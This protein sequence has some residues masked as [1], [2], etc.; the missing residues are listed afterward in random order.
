VLL[1]VALGLL[2]LILLG[3]CPVPD[4]NPGVEGTPADV[5]DRPPSMAV[6][7]ALGAET[8]PLAE[9]L[10]CADEV[11]QVEWDL[12]ALQLLAG[13][14]VHIALDNAGRGAADLFAFA[15]DAG[16]HLFGL[17]EDYSELDDERSCSEL[18]WS[19]FGC[20]EAAVRSSA[21]G[22]FVIAVAQWGGGCSEGMS[23]YQIH[24]AVNG[25][26]IDPALVLVQDD[27]SLQ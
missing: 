4:G 27:I 3:A 9:T 13:D 7:E 10:S 26:D 17:R 21:A 24:L 12:Y 1:R 8:L 11:G 23:D 6:C 14:C 18:P 5:R 20:P 15:Q 19:G 2:A 16:N 25:A 22:E